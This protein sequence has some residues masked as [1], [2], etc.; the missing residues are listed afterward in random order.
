MPC[1]YQRICIIIKVKW[2]KLLR[3][4]NAAGQIYLKGLK[5]FAITFESSK[6]DSPK[7]QLTS[8]E[9]N[10]KLNKKGGISSQWLLI[11]PLKL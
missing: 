11:P 6:Y 3:T 1:P 4:I 5:N 9:K 10:R 7:K 2:Y 8:L